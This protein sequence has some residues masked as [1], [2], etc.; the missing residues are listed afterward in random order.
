MKALRTAAAA[1]LI[2]V[3]VLAAGAD[4]FAR[5]DY[6]AQ[7]RDHANEGPSRRFLLGTDDVGRDRFSR[8]LHG[9]RVSLLCAPAAAL[10]AIA[11]GAVI[12][13]AAGYF[14]GWLDRAA[15]IAIDLFLSLPWLF[16]LLMLRAL[17]PLDAAGWISIAAT[18]LLLA[19]VGWAS[20]ARVVRASVAGMREAG[21]ILHARAYGCG[22]WRLLW[23]HMA[24]NLR[25]VLS[26]QFWVL[27]PVFLLTEANLGVL[28]LGVTEPIPSW[29][30]ILAEL[31]NYH[32]IPESP[33]I[34]APAA[35]LVLVVGSLH[36]LVSGR[37][38]WE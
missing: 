7:F 3:A 10:L 34:L 12:G 31:Q 5:H 14:G 1:V 6:A 37:G 27:V 8:L 29:G 26:A 36:F 33:W 16:A 2:G 21:P 38:A 13:L 17:L 19:G 20:G 23:F 30:N 15:G 24:P 28:G 18:F 22:T 9:V 32:R 25:P 4:A 35:L 11:I